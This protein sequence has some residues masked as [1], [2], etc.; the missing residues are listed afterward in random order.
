ML[1]DMDDITARAAHNAASRTERLP[2]RRYLLVAHEIAAL[3]LRKTFEHG[4]AVLLRHEKHLASGSR[5]LLQHLGDIG[6]PVLGQLPNLLDG[7]FQNLA[8]GS[9]I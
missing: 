5:N 4:C 6:L 8:Y 2:E 9:I 1:V 3:G 7:V